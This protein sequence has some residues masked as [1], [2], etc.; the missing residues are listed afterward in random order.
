MM[1]RRM[2]DRGLRAGPRAGGIVVMAGVRGSD[3]A[4]AL[5]VM[6][7]VRMRVMLQLH[8]V[9]GIHRGKALQ[10]QHD[11]QYRDQQAAEHEWMKAR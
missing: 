9:G 3:D 6:P 7:R 1:M 5:F 4:D 10:R 8:A 11:Q 2:I